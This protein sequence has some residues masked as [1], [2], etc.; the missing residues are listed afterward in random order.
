MILIECRGVETVAEAE[1]TEND[2]WYV[3]VSASIA[4]MEWAML[5]ANDCLR[6]VR[7]EVG[8]TEALD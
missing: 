3:L 5:F 1:M 8:V 4:E 7:A 6:L 2:A